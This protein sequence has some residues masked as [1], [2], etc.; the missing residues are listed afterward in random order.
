[1]SLSNNTLDCSSFTSLTTLVTAVQKYPLNIT[2]Q[3]QACP[4]ICSLAWGQGNSDFSGIGVCSIH[5][6]AK[7][8]QL[9]PRALSDDL[10]DYPSRPLGRTRSPSLGRKINSMSAGPGST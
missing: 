3:I 7:V 5:L 6:L 8:S 1:M 2:D 10:L 9:T 4:D